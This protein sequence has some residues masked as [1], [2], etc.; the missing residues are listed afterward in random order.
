MIKKHGQAL[1]MVYLIIGVFIILVIA[2]A[3]KGISE[4][5]V[6]LQS[7]L[8]QDALFMAEGA[9]EAAISNFTSAIANFQINSSIASYNVTTIFA[10]LGNVTVNSTLIRLENSERSILEGQTYV[11]E[12]NYEINTTVGTN[13]THPQYS[14]TNLTL[15]LIITRRLIPTFQH[16][17]FYDSD[18]EILPG[19]NMNLS[20]RI[21]TN[22][23]LYMDADSNSILRINST[24][25]ESAGDI[26]NQRKDSG[27]ELSGDVA[28]LVNNTSSYV[29]MSGFDC[30]NA[31]WA[32]DALTRWNGTVQSAVH[33]VTKST[34]PSVASIQPNGYYAINSGLN[35]TNG[36][37]IRNGV[38]ITQN[39]TPGNNTCPIGT[40]VTNGTLYNVREGKTINI[41]MIDMQKLSGYV[42]GNQ[43]YPNNMPANGLFYV[44][45][46]NTSS[47]EPG[48]E[49]INGSRINSTMGLTLVSNDPVY[50]K[51]DYNTQNSTS[52]AIICDS[53]DIL[54]NSWNNSNGSKSFSSRDASNTTVVSA[55]IAGVDVSQNGSYNGGLENYPRLLEDWSGTLLNISGSFVQ[56]WDTNSSTSIAKGRWI[57]GSSGGTDYYNPPQRNW[58]YNTNFNNVSRLP[59]FTPMAVEA[60]RVAWWV[61]STS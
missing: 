58:Y 34:A 17:V 37:I 41:T 32:T 55:F 25:V 29:N 4:R 61:N 5:N 51:G 46:G 50:I 52:T 26:F 56:L 30:D 60:T 40:I 28:I 47:N 7:K 27:A 38:V 31:T 8:N 24:C 10:S 1:I 44:T 39:A 36:T 11:Y 14:G 6:E 48:I 15:H 9:S 43:T 59:P 23:D 35:I 3:T 53:V 2:L 18:L 45:R 12:R 42:N 13:I 19:A 57:I 33:G 54:S 16:A 49:L 21:H 22:Q 20:G